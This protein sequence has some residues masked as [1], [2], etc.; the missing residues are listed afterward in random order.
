MRKRKEGCALARGTFLCFAYAR[1]TCFVIFR[2][3]GTTQCSAKTTTRAK[4]QAAA[5]AALAATAAVAAAARQRRNAAG[6]Q[7]DLGFIRVNTFVEKVVTL[8]K[9][10]FFVFVLLRFVFACSSCLFLCS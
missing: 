10:F 7:L 4:M 8:R 3:N 9:F 5:A 1:T 6:E 2:R